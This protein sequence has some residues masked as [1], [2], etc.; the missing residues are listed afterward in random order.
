MFAG[1]ERT[2]I[3]RTGLQRGGAIRDRRGQQYTTARIGFGRPA[4]ERRYRV[5][6]FA[7]IGLS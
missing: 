5:G 6:E 3:R 2:W 7:I 1:E 4:G